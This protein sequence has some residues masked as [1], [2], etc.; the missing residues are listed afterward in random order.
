MCSFRGSGIADALGKVDCHAA[1]SAL[2][3]EHMSRQG[4][5]C[6]PHLMIH[7]GGHG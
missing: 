7:S 4:D 5:M 3:L 6:A 2:A 1:S